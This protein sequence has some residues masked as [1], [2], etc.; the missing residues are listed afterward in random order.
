MVAELGRGVVARIT[1]TTLPLV[2]ESL[3]SFTKL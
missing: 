3:V 2:P 1:V